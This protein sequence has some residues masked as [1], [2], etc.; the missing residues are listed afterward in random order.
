[1]R[2]K[3]KIKEADWTKFNELSEISE[4]ELHLRSID[5]NEQVISEQIRKA[6]EA[7]IKKHQEKKRKKL[8]TGGLKKS[9]KKSKKRNVCVENLR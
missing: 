2:R 9:G 4:T 3:W 1:M 8:I 7:A 6:A 5:E